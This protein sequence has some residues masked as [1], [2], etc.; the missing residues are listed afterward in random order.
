M[1]EI[2]R[3]DPGLVA[4]I[5]SKLLRLIYVAYLALAIGASGVYLITMC[6]AKSHDPWL[7]PR[8]T[9]YMMIYWNV[10]IPMLSLMTL[11]VPIGIVLL[12]AIPPY[13]RQYAIRIA[14]GTM[15]VLIALH[16]IG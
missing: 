16:V 15:A 8:R 5:S 13:R 10:A 12:V 7:T 9:D 4:D 1:A 3:D 6:Y 11:L 2:S 14:I